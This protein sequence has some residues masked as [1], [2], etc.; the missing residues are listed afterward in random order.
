MLRSRSRSPGGDP[1]ARGR[2]R[3]RSPP[4]RT[5]AEQVNYLLAVVYRSAVASLLVARW[6]GCCWRS[7]RDF[8]FDLARP[9]GAEA[10]AWFDS[11]VAD[12]EPPP[13]PTYAD[14]VGWVEAASL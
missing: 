5:T 6:L 7:I 2:G 3:R 1:Q 11:G 4:R 14:F 9:L 10:Y 8:C 12:T 13:P